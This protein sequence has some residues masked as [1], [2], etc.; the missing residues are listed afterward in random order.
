MADL[1]PIRL[2]ITG[3]RYFNLNDEVHKILTGV[4]SIY[5]ITE[6]ATGGATGADELSM[7]WSLAHNIPVCTY[8]A[9]WKLLGNYAGNARNARMLREF[10]PDFA[11]AY[12][13]GPGTLDMRER[14][15]AA[16]ITHFVGTWTCSAQTGVKWELWKDP[17][18]G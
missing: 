4:R 16:R 17:I 12:P 5:D 3:G 10:K 2:L 18:N 14:L 1:A 6:V 9:N 7:L 13:G 8:D 15:R 11:V